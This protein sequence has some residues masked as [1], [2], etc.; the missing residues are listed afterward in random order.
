M[1]KRSNNKTPRPLL[2]CI[3]DGWGDRAETRDNAIKLARTPNWNRL[4]AE[5]PHGL[6]ETSGLAVGLPDGQMGNSEVGHMNIGAGRVVMQDLPRIDR[7]IADGSLAANPALQDA[8]AAVAAAGGRFHLL[9]LL[10][11]GGVHAHQDHLIALARII[12]GQG[13]GVVLHGFLDGRDTPPASAESYLRH[14]ITAVQGSDITIGSLSGRYYAMD[15]DER[16]D[17]VSLA[18]DAIAKGRGAAAAEPLT[19][20]AASYQAGVTDEFM[21]PCVIGSY[22]GITDGD[23]LLMGNFRADRAREILHALADP[24]FTAFARTLPHCAA[25]LGMTDYSTALSPLF[26][27]LFPAETLHDILGEVAAKAGLRQLRIAET[28]KYAHVTFFLNG[29]EEHV[30]PGE[31]RILVP[32]PKVA[33]YDL[34][35]EMSAIEVTDRLVAAIDSGD[36]DLIIANYANGDM[37]GHTGILSAAIQAV[38][39]I[40]AC[41]GRLSASISASGGCMLVTADHGNAE[42]MRDPATGEPYTAHTIGR[43]PLVLVNPPKGVT[44]LEDGRLADIAPTL[45]ALIG[46]APPAAMTG[47]NLLRQDS[48]TAFAPRLAA[49]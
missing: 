10:S 16:W 44:G 29:G 39:V 48:A 45:L 27:A 1:M 20:L 22:A 17:R 12:A 46:I 15:R 37:V 13:V 4:L 2:L 24:G 31:D 32:S 9:G 35:P 38:E 11:P 8:I 49:L 5:M 30:Y 47:R 33:T 42:M 6:L 28:E 18:F 43:V 23:G 3:L 34:Q 19:A 21:L 40:D 41:L 26:P 25:R 14:V 7:A 36:Y